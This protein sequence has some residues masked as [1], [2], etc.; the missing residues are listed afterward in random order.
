MPSIV[1]LRPSGPAT[2]RRRPTALVLVVLVTASLLASCANP[3]PPIAS[4]GPDATPATPGSP[5]PG[6]TPGVTPLPTTLPGEW[7]ALSLPPIEPV[8]TLEATR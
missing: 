1:T 7:S 4:P 5:V 3:A 8:A 6:A 2:A